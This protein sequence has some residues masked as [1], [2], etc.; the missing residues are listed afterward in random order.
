MSAWK[1][2]VLIPGDIFRTYISKIRTWKRFKYNF[3]QL[4]YET[5]QDVPAGAKLCLSHR[6]PLNLQDML[7]DATDERE[8]G[9]H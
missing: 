8:T 6:E 4:W 9:T 5:F 2:T 1:G 3:F 7:G